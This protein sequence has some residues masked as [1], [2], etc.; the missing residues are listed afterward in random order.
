MLS[1][2]GH[3]CLKGNR[4]EQL[5]RFQVVETGRC[6]L[7]V[8][9]DGFSQ[10]TARPHYVDWLTARV[11]SL[12]DSGYIADAVCREISA[13]LVSETGY[14]GKASVAFVVSDDSEYRFATLGD[15]RIYWQS[16]RIRTRDH[17]LAE[18]YAARGFC[19][20]KSLRHHPLRNRLTRWASVGSGSTHSLEWQSAPL[21][22]GEHM[23]MCTDGFWS[24]FDEDHIY[25]IT[26]T[27]TLHEHCRSLRDAIDNLT[28]TLLR[29]KNSD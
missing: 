15:T 2:D 24:Q 25:A 26:S 18:R 3:I 23:L 9:A 7:F 10:C 12:S 16:R 19:S 29:Y 27:T 6:R 14:P 17:S 20:S 22:E 13:F 4:E 28:V 21:E 8:M 11:R 1:C 5:D